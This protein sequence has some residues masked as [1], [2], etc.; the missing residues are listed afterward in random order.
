MPQAAP[1]LS[2]DCP[3]REQATLCHEPLGPTD[4]LTQGR[5]CF[6]ALISGPT[7]KHVQQLLLSNC[8][9]V[10][11]SEARVLKGFVSAGMRADPGC[12]PSFNLVICGRLPPRIHPPVKEKPTR[13]LDDAAGP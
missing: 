2:L 9:R 7:R 1:F 3:S 4:R 11:F 12:S 13:V 8:A 10:L 6:E 5:R